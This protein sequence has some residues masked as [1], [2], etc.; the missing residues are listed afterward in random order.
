[1]TNY[2]LITTLL[3]F[4]IFVIPS[5]A[6]TV[7]ELALQDLATGSE[8][9]VQAQV[10]SVVTQWDKEDAAIY[11]YIKLKIIDDFI[12]SG[13]NNEIVIRQRGGKLNGK[14][15]AVK[16]ACQYSIGTEMVL[17]LFADNKNPADYQ[18]VGMYQGKYNIYTDATGT[19]R[20]RRDNVSGVRLLSKN[21]DQ[22]VQTG[23]DLTLDSFK[24]SVLHFINSFCGR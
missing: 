19:K 4:L 9:I 24:S 5:A 2:K 12:G 17:F 3:T 13:E 7:F 6:T 11:T 18:T 16:G 10:M 23:N 15:F 8:K 20:V 22:T 14:S 21:E 1:M